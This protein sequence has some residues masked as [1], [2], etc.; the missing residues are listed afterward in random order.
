MQQEM[1]YELEI[2]ELCDLADH[3]K[4]MLREAAAAAAARPPEPE[5]VEEETK[6]EVR[7]PLDQAPQES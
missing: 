1:W 3:A 6:E 4:E 7:T 2:R 5:V